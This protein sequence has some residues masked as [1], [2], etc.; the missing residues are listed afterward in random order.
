MHEANIHVFADCIGK[1]RNFPKD[2]QWLDDV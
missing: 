2:L 1:L